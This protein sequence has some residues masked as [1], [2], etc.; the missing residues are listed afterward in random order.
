MRLRVDWSRREISRR[1]RRIPPAGHAAH[2]TVRLAIVPAIPVDDPHDPRIA[3]YRNVPDPEL[4][5]RDGAFVAEGR[6]VVKRLLGGERLAVRS[7]MLTPASL[8]SLAEDVAR[9][10]EIPVYVVPQAL[11]NGVTGFNLHRGCL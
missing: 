8:A 5:A 2:P 7:V 10:P 3:D 9:R 1:I 4:I 11:M 6:L